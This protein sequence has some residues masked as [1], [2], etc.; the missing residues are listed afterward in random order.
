[1]APSAVRVTA[2][3]S[4]GVRCPS[5]TCGDRETGSRN[6][7]ASPPAGFLHTLLAAGFPRSYPT[8][9]ERFWGSSF[10]GFPPR[11]LVSR[12]R[13]TT[14]MPL[15][16]RSLSTSGFAPA[17][18]RWSR[19]SSILSWFFVLQGLQSCRPPRTVSGRGSPLRFPAAVPA[20]RATPALRGLF[21]D[22]IRFPLSR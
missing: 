3:G 10:R 19:G 2:S 8:N 22:G 18:I 15:K 1:M 21:C 12:L 20:G 4:P 16:P 11:R 6:V 7:P 9:R 5:S 17:R 14:L 13:V